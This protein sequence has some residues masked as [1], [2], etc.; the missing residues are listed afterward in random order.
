[1]YFSPVR[2]VKGR[3]GFVVDVDE[4]P[5]G[6][7]PARQRPETGQIIHLDQCAFG[8]SEL[9]GLAALAPQRDQDQRAEQHFFACA[10]QPFDHGRDVVCKERRSFRADDLADRDD[11]DRRLVGDTEIEVA[12]AFRRPIVQNWTEAELH[13]PDLT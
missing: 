11:I 3:A 9:F 13:L 7:R 8:R 10:L 2:G 4:G 12:P 6:V 5:D 1:M